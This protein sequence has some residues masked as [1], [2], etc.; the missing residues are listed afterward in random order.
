MLCA[1][2]EGGGQG[3]PWTTPD[4]GECSALWTPT[5]P[6]S[7]G[8]SLSQPA[9]TQPS[10]GSQPLSCQGRPESAGLQ[11]EEGLAAATGTNWRV[12][13]GQ[14]IVF[15]LRLQIP[16]HVR[17][18][19]WPGCS[20]LEKREVCVCV[21]SGLLAGWAWPSAQGSGGC[22]REARGRVSGTW[23]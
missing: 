23:A 4:S 16:F 14:R 2:A 22:G 5:P 20:H 10:V 18:S 1:W 12:A 6:E 15:H 13:T 11:P 21:G 3:Q 9:L 19:P 17:L 8:H 7:E